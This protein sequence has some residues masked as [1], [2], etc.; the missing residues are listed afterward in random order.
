MNRIRI[1]MAISVLIGAMYAATGL[2][3]SLTQF[4]IGL[5]VVGLGMVGYGLCDFIESHED[6]AM[7]RGRQAVWARRDDQ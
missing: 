4:G 7:A 1:G 5:A 2:F 6:E 3:E